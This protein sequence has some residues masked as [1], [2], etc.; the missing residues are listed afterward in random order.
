MLICLAF[1]RPTSPKKYNFKILPILFKLGVELFGLEADHWLII[2]PRPHSWHSSQ[3]WMGGLSTPT[4][5]IRT[6]LLLNRVHSGWWTSWLIG[7]KSNGKSPTRMTQWM[8]GML[9]PVLHRAHSLRWSPYFFLSQPDNIFVLHSLSP[10]GSLS[11][12]L[13]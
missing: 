1:S 9:W 4:P 11:F 12:F 5:F 8:R 3:P 2:G 13:N 10:S 6:L 7:P